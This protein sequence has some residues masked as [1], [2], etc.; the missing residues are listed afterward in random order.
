MRTEYLVDENGCWIWQMC[1]NNRGYGLKWDREAR[2]LM[3]AHRCYYEHARGPI[4]EGMQI[5]HLC[6]VKA[7]VNVAHLEA[8]TP[9][10]NSQRA[11]A[12]RQAAPV[13]V[14]ERPVVR[15]VDPRECILWRG[16]RDRDDYGAKWID[17][18]RVMVHRWAYEQAFG[19]TTAQAGGPATPTGN[20]G[21]RS[22]RLTV[23]GT[24]LSTER[25]VA[26]VVAYV[27]QPSR[28][29]AQLG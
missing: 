3:M 15:T 11:F 24:L 27:L 2:R 16:C 7:C 19:A 22:R 5:D 13:P 25:R 29:V 14:R 10:V 12:L 8:V 20:D 17:G 23:T 28:D 18:K 1:R 21:G 6:N 9:Q 26:D 4:P